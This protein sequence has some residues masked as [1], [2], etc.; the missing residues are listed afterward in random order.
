MHSI[1]DAMSGMSGKRGAG[2]S[3]AMDH[4]SEPKQESEHAG[5]APEH[6]KALHEEMGG[7][8]MHVHQHEA[9]YTTHHVKEDG[10]VEGPHDHENTEELKH[11]M[12][13]FFDE[14]E[15]EPSS[16]HSG[17]GNHDGLM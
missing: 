8:H 14:E 17:S 13:K 15:H 6:L 9:G 1:A 4:S 10:K 12:S 11:H 16:H 7:K 3:G 2:I 5:G